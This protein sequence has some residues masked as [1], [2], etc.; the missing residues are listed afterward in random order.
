V[1]S[2]KV[3]YLELQKTASTLIGSV[4][5]DCFGAEHRYPKH[6]RMPADCRDRFVIGSVRNPWDYYVSLWSFGGGGEGGLHKRLTQ[7]Q[8]RRAARSLPHLGPLLEELRK[9]TADWKTTYVEPQTPERFRRWLSRVHD[10]RRAHEIEKPYGAGALC[11]VAGY[12]TYRYCR[13]YAGDLE[14]VLGAS[15]SA[16]L[17]SAVAT[18]WL[19]DAFVRTER[20]ADDLLDAVHRAG[21]GVDD[22]L[23]RAV[24]ARTETM[25]N[26]SDHRPYTDYYDDDSRDLVAERDALLIERH[27]YTYGS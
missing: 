21:Y 9:P 1:V 14:S 7:R 13:L 18:G 10:P 2:D 12:A 25:L 15:S 11:R 3:V 4:L 24:R 8:L 23:E 17:R 26:R 27:G 19:P 6:G 20:L 5:V 16:Q 22:D